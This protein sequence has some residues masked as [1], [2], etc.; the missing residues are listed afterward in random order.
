MHLLYLTIIFVY[1]QCYTIKL[2][3]EKWTMDHQELAEK[4]KE[5]LYE[6]YA[7]NLAKIELD[8]LKAEYTKMKVQ[9]EKIK[10]IVILFLCIPTYF[11]VYQSR[12]L[13]LEVFKKVK[14]NAQGIKGVEY[15]TWLTPLNIIF[16]FS[17]TYWMRYDVYVLYVQ[18]NKK[19]YVIRAIIA[20]TAIL[21]MIFAF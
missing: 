8:E 3:Y 13:T 4:Y 5:I 6:E 9:T 21:C 2:I 12:L 10:L 11:L 15:N 18:K 16:F 14:M 1:L 20:T 19:K 17:K 7:E